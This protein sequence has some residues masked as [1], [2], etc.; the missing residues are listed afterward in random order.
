MGQWSVFEI[1]AKKG[2]KE[3][4]EKDVAPDRQ[5]GLQAAKLKEWNK[6]VSSG[7]I[8]VHTGEAA[9]KIRRETPKAKDAEV[10]ICDYRGGCWSVT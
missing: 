2:R 6:L 8:V 4:M 10:T 5:S 1:A 7:A 9:A 3:I